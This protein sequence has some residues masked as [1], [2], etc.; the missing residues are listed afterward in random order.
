MNL[1]QI[2]EDLKG[3]PIQA[4]QSYMNGANPEVPPFLA[5]GEMQRRQAMMQ[6][7]EMEQG[8]EQ[9]MAPS[10]KEQLEQAAGLMALQQER[11]Q[12]AQQQMMQQ[13]MV[14]PMPTSEGTPQPEMQPSAEAGV[15]GLPV[16]MGMAAG[17]I[18]PFQEGGPTDEV[19]V[20]RQRLETLRQAKAK[21]LERGGANTMAID[22]AIE[23]ITAEIEKATGA[24][25]AS[26]GL[27]SLPMDMEES[28]PEAMYR[29]RSAVRAQD[30]KEQGIKPVDMMTPGQRGR[31]IE[32]PSSGIEQLTTPTMQSPIERGIQAEQQV[33]EASGLGSLADRRK[34]M[35]EEFDRS[36]TARR[37][38][39]LAETLAG[40]MQGFGGTAAAGIAASRRNRAEREAQLNRMYGLEAGEAEDRYTGIRGLTEDVLAPGAV[41]ST[42]T[43]RIMNEVRALQRDGK[44]AEAKALL[45]LHRSLRFA[46]DKPTVTRDALV[47]Q[48]MAAWDKLDV[49]EKS[50]YTESGK[51]QQDF[52]NE[53]IKTYESAVGGAPGTTGTGVPK[54]QSYLDPKSE[55][56]RIKAMRG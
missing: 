31:S 36:E 13:G 12:Q 37:R 21:A 50:D 55:A 10:V 48:A 46:P 45:D 43:E 44:T 8:S 40:G 23:Q 27:G 47:K 1:I 42:E 26:G 54:A 18:V 29:R 9:G 16:E 35:Q 11:S 7:Q 14:A 41:K 20:L 2:Q 17:G 5:A 22:Q 19:S 53:Y 6:R 28:S 25:G 49:L 15:A 30:V 3:M 38:E 39:G 34:A 52:V 51:G 4:L 56:D 24:P 32:E 33:F